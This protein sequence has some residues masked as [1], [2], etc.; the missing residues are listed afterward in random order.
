MS[1]PSFNEEGLLPIGNYPLTFP[2]LLESHLV[3]GTGHSETWDRTWRGT[4]VNNL[5]IMVLQLWDVGIDRVFID[6]SFV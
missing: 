4:L 6:G 2:Q 3:T 5:E 1:L